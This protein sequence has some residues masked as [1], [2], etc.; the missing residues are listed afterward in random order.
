MVNVNDLGNLQEFFGSKIFRIPKWQRPYSWDEKNW[1]DVWDDIEE[2]SDNNMNHYWGTITLLKT[3]EN[4]NYKGTFYNVFDVIDGQQRIITIILLIIAIVERIK[5]RKMKE[6]IINT[7]IRCGAVFRFEL[8]DYEDDIYLKN[9]INGQTDEVTRHS[10]RQLRD[11][12][13]TFRKYVNDENVNSMYEN[14]VK[15]QFL[16]FIINDKAM[17]VKTFQALNDRGKPLTLIDKTKSLLMYYVVK[18]LEEDISIKLLDEINDYFGDVFESYYMIKNIGDIKKIDYIKNKIHEDDFLRLLYHY[19]CDHV[20]NNYKPTGITYD[21]SITANEVYE[22]F[23]I[24][25]CKKFSENEINEFSNE[26]ADNFKRWLKAFSEILEKSSKCHKN[27][28]SLT[29]L[30]IFQEID[31][32][33]YPLI[34]NL[35]IENVLDDEL[36]KLIEILDFRV[37]KLRGTDP[38]ANIYRNVI[39][40][41]KDNN[42]IEDIKNYKDWIKGYISWWASDNDIKNWLNNPVFRQEW[43]RYVLWEYNKEFDENFN[44]I[45]IA[46]FKDTKR[47]Q[48]DHIIPQ[49]LVEGIDNV[50]DKNK[51]LNEFGFKNEEEFKDK[52][53]Y[54]GNLVL[55]EYNP[56]AGSSAPKN[57]TKYYRKSDFPSA[58]ELS[59][60]IKEYGFDKNTILKQNKEIINFCLKRWCI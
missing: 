47:I 51:I 33:I 8:G 53:D 30:T 39:S 56:A 19:F 17:G 16:E 34:I 20:K 49:G 18:K 10:Q 4:K 3:N 57:K 1:D 40:K 9:L 5:D 12:L 35:Y 31:A 21:Y 60:Q 36:I 37:Y 59:N 6:I 29:K 45:D 43:V 22:D 2:V 52:I 25:L 46:K 54:L 58:I 42:S 15:S 11:G 48:I 13:K 14:I 24:P 26:F 50:R 55:F 28:Y 27:D 32:V 41:I 38:T 44:D 7:Y 23:L